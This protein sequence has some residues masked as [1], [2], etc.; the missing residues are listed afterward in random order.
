MNLY[1]ETLRKKSSRR[2][3]RSVEMEGKWRRRFSCLE[4]NAVE[5]RVRILGLDQLDGPPG[6]GGVCNVA[7]PAFWHPRV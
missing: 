4:G 5:I 2:R 7:A 1:S 3:R 6:R